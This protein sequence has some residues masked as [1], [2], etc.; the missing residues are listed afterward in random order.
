M[1]GTERVVGAREEQARGAGLAHGLAPPLAEQ[2]ERDGREWSIAIL[3]TLV[4]L[5]LTNVEEHA[6]RVD[7]LD[8]KP[9][10]LAESQTSRVQDGD[11]HAVAQR[12]ERC[13]DDARES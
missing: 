5:G 7:V 2:F 6:S 12:A 10:D 11:E 9:A 13:E 4:T 3:V 8:T 1:E